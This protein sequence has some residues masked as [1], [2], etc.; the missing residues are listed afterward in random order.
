MKISTT[1]AAAAS[2]F[3]AGIASAARSDPWTEQFGGTP[4]LSFSG[5]TTFAH[6]PHERCL[7]NIEG[8][9]DVAIL[10]VPY[11]NAVSYRP[12]KYQSRPRFPGRCIVT[13]GRDDVQE[14]DS[15]LMVSEVDLDD[16]DQRGVIRSSSA[17]TLT[18]MVSALYVMLHWHARK[19]SVADM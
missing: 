1:S 4:D 19:V 10:G 6:L 2:L 12:G 8:A 15:D 11:D 13:D 5:I 7:D 17:S 18:P 14:L 3:L 16:N 9:V